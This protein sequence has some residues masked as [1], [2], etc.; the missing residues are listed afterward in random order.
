MGPGSSERVVYRGTTTGLTRIADDS[1]DF[2]GG[3]I[4][5]SINNDGTVAFGTSVSIGF[6][7]FT[8][9]GSS[10]T[11]IAL[12]AGIGEP[13]INN[14]GTV[15]FVRRQGNVASVQTGNGGPLTM[16]A[17]TADRTIINQVSINDDGSVAFV[18]INSDLSNTL[19]VSEN[20]ILREV[21]TVDK[22]E[23]LQTP[24]L[25][26][27]GLLAF[28]NG[29]TEEIFIGQ[30]FDRVIGKGDLLFGSVIQGVEFWGNGL[31]DSGQMAIRVGFTDGSQGVYRAEPVTEP[32]LLLEVN[33]KSPFNV[34]LKGDPNQAA[35][36]NSYQIT[37]PIGS[38]DPT[39]WNSLADQGFEGDYDGNGT[40][41]GADFLKF[42]IDGGTPAQLAEWEAH[43][44]NSGPGSGWEESGGIGTNFLGETFLLG[45]S[46]IAAGASIDL[47][48]I[49]KKQPGNPDLSE[50]W[51][52]SFRTDDG[53][54]LPGVVTYVSG[55]A[56]ASAVP[57]PTTSALA[58]AALCL[59]ISRRRAF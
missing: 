56:A 38:L 39:G 35:D 26:N 15:A 47:G 22:T 24:S 16:I 12:A 34:T 40:I 45:D 4:G 29:A 46:T 33:T 28:K 59:A 30:H 5:P 32:I 23:S 3:F 43:Y 8:G 55:V 49:F 31:N 19:Y 6:G 52:F 41:D 58:L 25:N 20:Q 54:I 14:D 53:T 37:S 17:E 50:D 21:L 36:I 7:M 10:L 18:K 48:E 11:T 13:S 1:G 9:N 44:G 51:V 42:Q 27:N 2:W 57:E